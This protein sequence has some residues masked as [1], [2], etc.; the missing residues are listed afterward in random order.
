MTRL[1]GIS[2][3]L[4]ILAG[5]TIVGIAR[6]RRPTCLATIC[7][8]FAASPR[9]GLAQIILNVPPDPAPP[10]LTNAEVLNLLPG[11]R[12]RNDFLVG[13]DAVLNVQGGVVGNNLRALSASAI[14]LSSGIIGTGLQA[15]AGSTVTISGGRVGNDAVIQGDLTLTGGTIGQFLRISGGTTTISGGRID[16]YSS[17]YE[18]AVVRMTGGIVDDVDQFNNFEMRGGTVGEFSSYNSTF[19]GSDFRLDGRPIGGL[20]NAGDEVRFNMPER[21]LFT[22]ILADGTPFAF[23]VVYYEDDIRG[24]VRLVREDPPPGPEVI[25]VYSGDPVPYGIHAGQTLNLHPEGTL[26]EHFTAGAGS[27]LNVFGGSIGRNFEAFGG[28]VNVYG[29]V[30]GAELDSMDAFHGATINVFGGSLGGGVDTHS[31]SIVN[32]YG[33]VVGND[34]NARDGAVV[35]V[36]GGFVEQGFTTFPYAQWNLRGGSVQTLRVI[37]TDAAGATPGTIYG[38]NFQLDRQPIEGLN[39][40][41]DVVVLDPLDG[42]GVLLSGQFADGTRFIYGDAT[43]D[44]LRSRLRLVQTEL[45]PPGRI[46]FNVPDDSPPDRVVA[47]QTLNLRSGGELPDNFLAAPGSIVHIEDGSVGDFFQAVDSDVTIRGGNIGGAFAAFAGAAVTISGGTFGPTFDAY[48]GTTIV[49]EGTR[50]TLDGLTLGEADEPGESML[51]TARGNHHLQAVLSDGSLFDLLLEPEP[52]DLAFGH[53]YIDP[54]ATLRLVVTGTAIP[55]P[56]AV[57]L[58]LAC[59][60]LGALGRANR[61]KR[62]SMR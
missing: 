59:T 43:S 55:E 58:L 44:R 61:V 11:G 62:L 20:Q 22:G 37:G 23:D 60:L 35:N 30:I 46:V 5:G 57:T 21:A 47:R 9:F 33:G 15:E 36:E 17:A 13:E 42:T 32:V 14:H 29:G 56:G 27:T 10:L 52:D 50:F 7:I 1:H 18:N 12:I 39:D 26:P 45:P 48:R 40:P 19:Y 16:R 38:F 31:G 34:F 6:L 25:N 51:I 53:D 49:L 2:R 24:P 3:L 28:T 41:G 8:L 4:A 54:A